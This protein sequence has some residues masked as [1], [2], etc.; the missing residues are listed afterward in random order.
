MKKLGQR[1]CQIGIFVVRKWNRI[2]LEA[3]ESE[4]F[5]FVQSIIATLC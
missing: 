2:W 5:E 1:V 3:T 4:Y